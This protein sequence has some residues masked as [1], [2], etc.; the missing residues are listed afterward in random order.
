[1]TDTRPAQIIVLYLTNIVENLDTAVE[2]G[3]DKEFRIK[4]FRIDIIDKS[5]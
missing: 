3:Y 4:R 2:I 1:M 5:R